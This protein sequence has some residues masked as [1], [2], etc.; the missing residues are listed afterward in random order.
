VVVVDDLDERL[1]LAA[2][3]LAVLRHTAGDLLGV[4]LD[5]GD[6]R[7]GVGVSLSSGIL[8]LDDDDLE[9]N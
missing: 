9:A 1:D 8:G 4:T 3:G 6:Q 2:L 7:V 5:T